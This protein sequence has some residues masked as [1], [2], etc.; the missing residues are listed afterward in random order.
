MH[1]LEKARDSRYGV[2]PINCVNI[3]I[4]NLSC[5][6]FPKVDSFFLYLYLWI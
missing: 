1:I 4:E 2:T 6:T 5:Q 3:L